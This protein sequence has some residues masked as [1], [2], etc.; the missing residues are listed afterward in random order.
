MCIFDSPKT[1]VGALR[2]DSDVI[3]SEDITR[4]IRDHNPTLYVTC[5]VR[6]VTDSA[7][8]TES[9]DAPG[10]GDMEHSYQEVESYMCTTENAHTG[11]IAAE[12]PDGAPTVICGATAPAITSTDQT[13][14]DEEDVECDPV[15]QPSEGHAEWMNSHQYLKDIVLSCTHDE[16]KITLAAFFHVQARNQFMKYKD[17]LLQCLAS[18]TI[19]LGE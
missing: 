9:G 7:S 16:V 2:L 4:D 18:R 13:N 14:Q 12:E 17:E 10:C 6:G 15:C 11:L 1:L 5:P 8:L 3:S 19:A